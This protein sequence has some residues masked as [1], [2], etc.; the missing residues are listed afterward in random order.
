MNRRTVVTIIVLLGIIA[1]ALV[2]VFA[3]L[4]KPLTE[5]PGI[6]MPKPEDK[7]GNIS[8]AKLQKEQKIEKYYNMDLEYPEGLL[9]ID[10]YVERVKSDFLDIV[11][12]TDAQAEYEN[13]G[14]NRAYV[15][16]MKTVT[17]TS[18]TTVTYRL[19]TYMYTGGAH[20]GTFV[21]TFTYGPNGKII[22][23]SDILRSPD[24]LN[25][26]SS[27]ARLYF[28]A[29]LGTENGTEAIDGGTE[30]NENNFSSWYVTDSV[31]TF[32]FQQYQVGSYAIGIQEFPI[33]RAEAK[34]YLNI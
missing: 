29:K 27:A 31:V 24:S 8:V 6:E 30:A 25:S 17:Y 13:V 18:S 33:S 11:P 12:K 9:D 21:A 15:L 14:V 32:V 4:D 26:L 16:K 5:I 22:N 23:L 7:E 10:A 1:A 19:E 2:A 20:G 3:Y 28:Y 34:V